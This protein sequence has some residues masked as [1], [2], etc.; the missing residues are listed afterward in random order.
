MAFRQPTQHFQPLH[1]HYA[2]SITDP[3]V[4]I[5]TQIS[6]PLEDSQE[7]VLFS[8]TAPSTTQ[9]FT[10]STERTAG[11][12]HLSD[13]GSLDTAAGRSDV[14][15]EDED[16][17][18][19]SDATDAG[20]DVDEEEELDSLDSHLHAFREPSSVYHRTSQRGSHGASVGAVFPTHDGL[21]A[22]PAS[23]TPAQ[24]QI[25]RFEQFNP[26][27][28]RRLSTQEGERDPQESERHQR[29]QAWRME[30]SRVLLDEI[31]RET[32]RRQTSKGGSVATR[33]AAAEMEEDSVTMGVGELRESSRVDA[34]EMPPETLEDEN[35][36]FWERITRRVIRDLMGI[37]DSLLSVLFGESLP[38]EGEEDTAAAA[39]AKEHLATGDVEGFLNTSTWGDRLLE[40][41]ARELGTLVNHLSEHPG[42]FSSYLR[43]Q[44]QQQKASSYPAP[45]TR[46][47]R[48]FWIP[49]QPTTPSVF[50]PSTLSPHFN[51]TLPQSTQTA[52]PP[53][54]AHAALWGIEEAS[55]EASVSD[56]DGALAQRAEAERL[57]R[58]REYW[59]RELD[60]KTVL[61]YIRNRLTAPKHTPYT[62]S[63]AI[64][65]T[66]S[67]TYPRDMMVRQHHPLISH[68]SRRQRSSTSMVS[69]APVGIRR[70]SSSCA[71]QS[72]K[73]K[74]TNHSGSSRHYWD[75]GG[76]VGSVVGPGSAVGVGS[77]GEA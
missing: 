13:L 56:A 14:E 17:E 22:F 7:W 68:Y 54:I 4:Q 49:A 24:E 15:G 18:I 73:E 41:I 61:R 60:L 28:R 42:A 76:S 71:S 2:P 5:T 27:R 67:A 74:K 47:Q 23:S 26:R 63:A 8:P 53:P 45:T 52:L 69:A 9:T 57:R 21:G 30:Q 64:N 36:T 55:D 72:T 35:E 59:E 37:D 40:R 77:W 48:H 12:S 31:E 66:T 16:E 1:Q 39:A 38:D 10:A 75:L 70:S 20:G 51:P 46:P 3:E 65:T 32:R 34:A 33:S 25:W 29:I 62:P 11:A 50:S 6:A 44:Y 58:E 43:T 19:G